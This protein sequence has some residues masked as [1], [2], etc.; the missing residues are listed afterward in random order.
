MAELDLLAG[1]PPAGGEARTE[2]VIAKSV[3]R[4]SRTYINRIVEQINGSYEL[5][6]YDACSVMVRRLL[7]T[8]LIEAFEHAQ[9]S[10]EIKRADGE[11]V[12]LGDLID[13]ALVYG[14]RNLGRNCKSAMR[15]LKDVGDKSA[16][17]RRYLAHRSDIDG[18]VNDLRTVVQ[19]LIL[20]ASLQ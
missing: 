3:A 11:F 14:G 4:T 8:L 13:A 18:I 19:E 10:Q 6:Y 16:H 20:L 1:P 12:F 15:K 5:G 2:S 7:E 9:S 17:S